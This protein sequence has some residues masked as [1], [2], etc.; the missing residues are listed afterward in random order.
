MPGKSTPPPRRPMPAQA[1]NQ[2]PV[3]PGLPAKAAPKAV[4]M[5]GYGKKK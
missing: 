3:M 1:K 5:R 2:K 4:Q